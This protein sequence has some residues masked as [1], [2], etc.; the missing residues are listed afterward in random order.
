M[1]ESPRESR[2]LEVEGTKSSGVRM[3]DVTRTEVRRGCAERATREA[4]DEGGSDECAEVKRSGARIS[5][6]KTG[7]YRVHRSRTYILVSNIGRGP[8]W[9]L[10]IHESP[11]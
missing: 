11:G 4:R 5:N 8:K 3:L 10:G 2:G 1:D 6:I 7:D 9:L